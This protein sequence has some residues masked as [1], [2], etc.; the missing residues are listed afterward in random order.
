MFPFF[1]RMEQLQEYLDS[2]DLSSSEEE[3]EEEEEEEEV[4]TQ[5][6]HA[7]IGSPSI[8]QEEVYNNQHIGLIEISHYKS[9]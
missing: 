8:N 1:K 9:Y 6:Q 3:G 2:I 5:M 4:T 7:G